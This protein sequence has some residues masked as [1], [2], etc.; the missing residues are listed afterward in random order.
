MNEYWAKVDSRRS[1]NAP[2]QN[3]NIL[4]IFGW[5]GQGVKVKECVLL[6]LPDEPPVEIE[7]SQMNLVVLQSITIKE[8][9]SCYAQ[10]TMSRSFFHFNIFAIDVLVLCLL[11]TGLTLQCL[12][13][14]NDANPTYVTHVRQIE[15]VRE[16]VLVILGLRSLQF[17]MNTSRHAHDSSRITKRVRISNLLL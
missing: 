10:R 2:S 12:P 9:S 3:I 6:S 16:F 14:R 11:C 7:D 5:W 13:S 1:K 8:Y 4:V 15:Q 17:F